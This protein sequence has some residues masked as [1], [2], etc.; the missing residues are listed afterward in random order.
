MNPIP[1]LPP[2]QNSSAARIFISADHGMAVIYFLQSDVLPTLLQAGVEVVILTDDALIEGIRQRFGQPGVSVE[3]LRLKQLNAYSAQTSPE[4]QWWLH[5]FRRVGSSGRINTQAQ[6]CY[7]AQVSAEE[8]WKRR[9][10]MPLARGVVGLLRRSRRA[11]QMIVDA[12]QRFDPRVYTDLFEKYR[13]SLVVASTYGWR[14]DRYLL[15]QAHARGIKTAAA[16]VGWDNPSSYGLPATPLDAVT[17]WSALQKEELARGDDFSPEAVNIGGIPSYDGYFRK[18]WCIPRQEYFH[19][20]GLDPQRKLISYAASFVSF[21]PNYR[22][23]EALARLVSGDQLSAPAQLLVRL[24]PNHFQDVHLYAAERQ[25]IQKL[26]R[27]LPH[28]H[29]V[30]PVPLVS[31]EATAGG[32]LGYYSGE[33]MPEKSSMMAHSDVFTTVYSTMVVEAAIHGQPIVSVCLDTPG[34]W[35]TFRKYSLPLSQIG[36]WPTHDRFRRAQA[37]QVALDEAGLRQALDHYLQNPAADR[38]ARR[39]F[40]E[41]EVTYTDGN[42]GKRTGEYLLSLTGKR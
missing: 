6:D 32:S 40:I 31:G 12:Q 39:K 20:H 37:G 33:D 38:D 29:V 36:N 9:A 10:L 41:Q 35:N 11:R 34:G 21:A 16:I 13:P 18:T 42:A 15:R 24:H 30:E 5:F 19:L 14:Q 1:N 7:V 22:N 26:A 28:V 3:G 23:V 27:E 17:C 4:I 2:Q 25:A 8:G